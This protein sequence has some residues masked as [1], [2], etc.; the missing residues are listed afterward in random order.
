MNALG[1]VFDLRHLKAGQEVTL[2]F[3][4]T[5]AGMRPSTA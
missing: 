4:R 2:F 5:P 1:K 3:S